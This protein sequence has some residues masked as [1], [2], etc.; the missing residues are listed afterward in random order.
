MAGHFRLRNPPV[1]CA[2]ASLSTRAAL[3]ETL[4][5][6][7][8]L[9]C[10]N[11]PSQIYSHAHPSIHIEVAPCFRGV[12]RSGSSASPKVPASLPRCQTRF[13]SAGSVSTQDPGCSHL[14]SPPTQPRAHSLLL[15]CAPAPSL[16]SVPALPPG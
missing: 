16:I 12:L 9:N 5:R 10:C 11:R 6:N 1:Q 14:F 15:S 8:A 13:H 2:A 4:S 3:L 7:R